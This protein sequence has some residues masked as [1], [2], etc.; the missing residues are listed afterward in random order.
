MEE[1]RGPQDKIPL[2]GISMSCTREAEGAGAARPNRQHL[3]EARKLAMH[4]PRKP[5]RE[6][7]HV[8]GEKGDV[9]VGVEGCR[10]QRDA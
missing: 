7:E 9:H 8:A 2:E 3:G 10:S 6:T 4:W 5:Q 1:Q